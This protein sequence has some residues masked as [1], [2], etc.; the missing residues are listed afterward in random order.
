MTIIIVGADDIGLHLIDLV[1]G[2]GIDIVVVEADSKQAEAIH[3]E[4]DCTI[5]NDDP[6][7]LKTLEKAG[8]TRAEALVATTSRDEIDITT[9]LFGQEL[10]I[11]TTVS[12]INNTEHSHFFKQFGI[13]TI[14]NSRQLIAEHFYT[15]ITY[16]SIV[17]RQEFRENAEILKIQ[18]SE[19]ASIANQIISEA[20]SSQYLN[21]DVTV[22][23]VHQEEP[24]SQSVVP[25]G[26]TRI[27]AGDHVTLITPSDTLAQVARAF[28]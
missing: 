28:E 9:C 15:S 5:I 18:V 25:N 23:A 2:D 14:E 4:Y 24:G 6:A 16:P 8:G 22:I 19:G 7:S 27:L 11:D 1:A 26:D 21:S 12:V 3:T 13:Q 20:V 17:D 10:G